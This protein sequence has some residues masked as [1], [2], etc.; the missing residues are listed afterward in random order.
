[1][2]SSEETTRERWRL[3]GTWPTQCHCK[4]NC[5]DKVDPDLRFHIVATFNSLE[6]TATQNIYLR[7]Q[8]VSKDPV[9][10]G[11]GRSGGKF[12]SELYYVN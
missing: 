3:A 9:R 8:I 11:F 5:F 6:S 1:M 7:R 2:A 4:D 12:A 10:V